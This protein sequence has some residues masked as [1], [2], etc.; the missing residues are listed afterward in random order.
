[1]NPFEKMA[2]RNEKADPRRPRRALTP[3][4]VQQLLDAA[5]ARP[6]H[7]ALHKNRGDGPAKLSEATR[8]KLEARGRERALIY[9]TLA[10]TG[11]RYGEL[12]SITVAQAMFGGNTPHFLLHAKDEKARR[13]A[14]VAMPLE[15]ARDLE[16][17]A[18]GH[19]CSRCPKR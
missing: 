10:L 9:R 5:Q 11:L 7:E 12:R 6:L 15:L 3:E 2:K 4:E 16:A 19:A 1:M 18:E 14:N 13:G 8:A 17:H